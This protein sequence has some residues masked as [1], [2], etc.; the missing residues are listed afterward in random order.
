MSDRHDEALRD[1]Q[2]GWSGATGGQCDRI[3]RLARYIEDC[4]VIE[5]ERDALKSAPPEGRGTCVECGA[6]MEWITTAAA[7]QNDQ[8]TIYALRA[9]AEAAED[10]VGECLEYPALRAALDH[11]REVG[12]ITNE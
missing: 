12:A 10:V 3:S 6:Q 1:A 8:R 2:Y 4:R 7:T 11:A 9:V 5:A